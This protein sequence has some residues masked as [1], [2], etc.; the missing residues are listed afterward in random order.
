MLRASAREGSPRPAGP[1]THLSHG[2]SS[3]NELPVLV[4]LSPLVLMPVRLDVVGGIVL[5]A[6]PG[7]G[8]VAGLRWGRLVR[9]G[10][11]PRSAVVPP[12]ADCAGFLPFCVEQLP[13]SP[14]LGG[15][16]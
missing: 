12:D 10:A 13:H 14:G 9:H 8:I 6:T 7:L 3:G 16:G 15:G 2:R 4:P 5:R 11:P 1:L